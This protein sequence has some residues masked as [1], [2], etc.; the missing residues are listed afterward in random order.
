MQN[1]VKSSLVLVLGLIL[2]FSGIYAYAD[3]HST[4]IRFAHLSPDAPAVDIWLDE[5]IVLEDV[6]FKTVSRYLE[7]PTGSRQISITPANET[8]PVV[9]DATV[10]FQENTAYTIAATGLIGEDDLKPLVLVDDHFVNVETT[11]V[12]FA[13]IAP[14][15]PAVD[16]GPDDGSVL[17]GDIEFREASDYAQLPA[18]T[19][20]LEVRVAGTMDVALSVPDVTLEEGTNYTIFAIGTLEDGTLAALPIVDES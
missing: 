14:D 4:L 18:D 10:V 12:R 6:Q 7:L 3:D 11:K 2:I 9:I 13:H 15:A 8:T 17:F 16:V 5:G 1:Y 20:D 19:Y